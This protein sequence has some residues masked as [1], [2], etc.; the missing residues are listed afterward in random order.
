MQLVGYTMFNI[1]GF[2]SPDAIASGTII[3][4]GGLEIVGKYGSATNTMVAS[5]GYILLEGGAVSNVSGGGSVI[6]SGVVLYTAPANIV[7]EPNPA[8][9]VV[10]GAKQN[11]LDLVSGYTSGAILS[12]GEE[13]VFS[14]GTASAT[15]VDSGGV[16]LVYS[17]GTA[18]G[19]QVNSGGEVLISGGRRRRCGCDQR[20]R[21]RFDFWRY[22]GL[23][24]AKRRSGNRRQPVYFSQHR[25]CDGNQRRR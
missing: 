11:L 4:S 10:V 1:I 16:E 23:D 17:G 20:R 15:A 9:A 19:T 6:S 8:S 12:G 3:S 25:L 2:V 7:I 21:H 24:P 14:G 18:F 22:L 13:T 5:G